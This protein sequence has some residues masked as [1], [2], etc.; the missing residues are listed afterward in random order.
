MAMGVLGNGLADA[1]H[2][3]DALSVRE[4][5][6]SM[7][8]RLGYSDRNIF[9]VQ[10]NLA[11]TYQVLGRLEDALRVRKDV[12]SGI[13]KLRGEEH[14]DTLVEASNYAASLARLERFEEAKSLLLK[15]MPVARRVLGESHEITIKI[16]WIYGQALH[17]DPD[18]TLADLRK[19]VTTL[20]DSE[21]IAR[22]VLGGAHPATAAIEESL[23]ESRAALVCDAM[24]AM[25]PPGDA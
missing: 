9:I 2:H 10:G 21:R 25:T 8:R 6:L 7:M 16:G 24:A 17:R 15:T 19:A 18:A 11:I 3:E 14:E 4:A 22:R 1:E 23:R 5:Q 13:L 12:Y 20:E